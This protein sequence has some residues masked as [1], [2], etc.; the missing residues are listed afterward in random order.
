VQ[1][2][3]DPVGGVVLVRPAIQSPDYDPGVSGWA[4]KIDGSAE[5][6]DVTIRG[7][8]VLSGEALYY[9]GT[10]GPGALFL[11]IAAEAGTD[12]YGNT[13]PAGLSLH[14]DQGTITLTN[15][16]GDV[17]SAWVD[18]V[19]GSRIDMAVGGGAVVQSFTPPTNGG[20]DWEPGSLAASATNIFGNN[21]A[22]LSLK[23]PY[24][25]AHPSVCT[26]TMFG[27]SDTQGKN[28]IDATTQQFN[29]SGDLS[30]GSQ[31]AG[32]AQTPAPG[33]APGQTSVNVSFGKTFSAVP[34]VQLTPNSG[35]T[36]LDTA[37]IRWAVTNKSTTGFTINCWR[38][39]NNATNFEWW[40]SL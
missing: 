27:S 36:N 32:T 13:Y 1:F 30:A 33:G 35:S 39:T 11:S 16:D 5:F 37:N 24:N 31:A 26:L 29:V 2:D 17:V 6:N 14:S 7:G 10:P 20:A 18:T 40:A 15:S 22:V 12:D 4:V 23:S 8:T 19:N 3:D 21:T 28:R 34:S 25:R 9:N 38:D